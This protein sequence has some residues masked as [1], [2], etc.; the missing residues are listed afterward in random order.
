MYAA[1]LAAKIFQCLIA[2]AA[3]FDLELYQYDVLNAFLNAEID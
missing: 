2:L 3:A 1:T